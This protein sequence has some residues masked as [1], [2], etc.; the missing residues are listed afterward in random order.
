VKDRNDIE[1]VLVGDELLKGERSDAHL[2]YMGRA[3]GRCGARVARAHV[4]GDIVDAIAE[5]VAE[6]IAAARVLIVTGG[7]G[8]TPDDI[9]RVGVAK[10]LGLDLEF[11]EPTWEAIQR[12]FADRGRVASDVNRQQAE[13]PAGATIIPNQLGT[14][15]GFAIDHEGAT[16]VVLPGPPVEVQRMLESNVLPLVRG[17]F[18]CEPVR[19]ETYRTIGIGESAMREILGG[20]LDAITAYHVASLPSRIG[21]DIVLTQKSA[22]LGRAVLDEEADRLE[23][24]LRG[25]IGTKLYERGERSLFEVVHDELVRRGET[26]AVAESLSGG[27]IGKMFTDLPGSSAH[28]LADVVAYSDEAKI[29]Y[30]GVRTETLSAFG[31][32]SEETCTEMVHG[33][34]HRTGA[35]YGLATTGIAGP[36]GG[37]P[38][39]PLGLTFIGV[40]WDGGCLVKRQVYGGTRD[41]VRQRAVHGV[42]WLLYDH[43]VG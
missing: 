13:F 3:L 41:D 14:A 12:F 17:I 24:D 20:E 38:K 1:I 37:T 4:V 9:T 2:G 21:V 34:R 16:V 15:P 7:L 5:V 6:R 39:K 30:L 18:Q 19:V 42:V 26:L 31:A 11:D 32:V 27:W 28:F 22:R 8:P 40:S 43:L 10:A 29:E 25:V 33:I 36:E 23:R 35:T